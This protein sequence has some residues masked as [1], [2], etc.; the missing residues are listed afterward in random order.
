MD[1]ALTDYFI[2]FIILT[3]GILLGK[4]TIKGISLDTSAVFFVALIFGHFGFQIPAIIQQIGLI[5]FM[6]SIGIQAGPGFFDSFKKQGKKLILLAIIL[7]F[8]GGFIT[9]LFAKLFNI[10]INLAVGLFSGSFT[11]ASSLAI[12]IENT[13]STL[14]TLGFG[15]A[16]PFGVIG[17]VLFVRL[18]PKIF[19]ISIEQEE[20]LHL[21][22]VSS[23]HPKILTRNFIVENEEVFN[24]SIGELDLRLKTNTNISSVYEDDEVVNANAETILRKGDYIRASGTKKNLQKLKILIGRESKKHLPTHGKYAIKHFIVTNN[25]VINKPLEHLKTL[26]SN[27]ITITTIRR[28][29]IEIT[30][31]VHTRLRFGDRINV[32]GPE[33]NMNKM[34][35]YFGN[36]KSRLAEL[37]FLPIVLGVLIGILIGHIKIPVSEHTS[38]S[39]GVTGG[40]LISAIVLSR[41]GKTGKIIWNVSGPSNQF[42]RKL[43]LLFFLS[44]VGTD[45]GLKIM[46]TLTNQ[47]L[48][49]FFV[50]IIITLVPMI[51]TLIIG[52][53]VFKLNFLRLMGAITGSMLSTPA[54]SAI[55]PI[56]KT[57]APQ[58]AYATVYPMAL[59]LII[60]VSQIIVLF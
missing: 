31:N 34:K 59:I 5:F 37:D 29:G 57:D 40:V 14:P 44:G 20:K 8:S 43:G 49:L 26:H 13:H 28:S 23:D 58:V 15:I 18:S 3:L 7:S 41:I 21:K 52:R 50:G 22:D 32:A 38:F 1:F 2:L 4:V 45:A 47:G 36:E 60:L 12:T 48:H 53:Y 27:D 55:E 16:F 17:V 51:S 56:T 39:L 42:L 11:S 6:F 19:G 25:K 24:K 33:S 35:K 46:S 10:D 54:L 9:I 30:P